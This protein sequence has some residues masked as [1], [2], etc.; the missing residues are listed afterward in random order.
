MNREILR[1]LERLEVT[2]DDQLGPSAIFMV[3][4]EADGSKKEIL[5]WE[6]VMVS[7]PLRFTRE[8]GESAEECGER[9]AKAVRALPDTHPKSVPVLVAVTE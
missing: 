3:V 1:R 9:A 5:G 4:V 6:Q 8:P 2:N 7:D